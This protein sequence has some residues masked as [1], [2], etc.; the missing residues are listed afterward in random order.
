MIC[1]GGGGGF[2]RSV[3]IAAREHVEKCGIHGMSVRVQM[4]HPA[5]GYLVHYPQAHDIAFQLENRCCVLS[6]PCRPPLQV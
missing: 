3:T 1:W 4:L 5:H 2:R 6:L